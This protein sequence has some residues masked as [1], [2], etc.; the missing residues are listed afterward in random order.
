MGKFVSGC[1]GYL[2]CSAEGRN[3]INHVVSCLDAIKCFGCGSGLEDI[4]GKGRRKVFAESQDG[5]SS[6]NQVLVP[7]LRGSGRPRGTG[8]EV[9]GL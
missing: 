7:Q 2:C 3:L 4:V 8:E 1:Q 9:P 6:G 5:R